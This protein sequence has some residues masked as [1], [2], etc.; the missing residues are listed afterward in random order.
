MSSSRF[1]LG[2]GE[3][4]DGPTAM[5][6]MAQGCVYINA[7]NTPPIVYDGKP[8]VRPYTSQHP[9]VENY[10][11]EPYAYT[12]DL[13]NKTAVDTTMRRIRSWTPTPY[14]HKYNTESY[15]VENLR[16]IFSAQSMCTTATP[17][18]T[19]HPGNKVYTS[20]D[21]WKQTCG[22]TC[23]SHQTATHPSITPSGL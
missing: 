9:F 14:R 20:W 7:K 2:V 10:V 6:A 11:P 18:P 8:T 4:I 12:I 23:N 16:R 21:N 15:Y 22:G 5:E 3:P 19:R 1:L 13:S 17:V